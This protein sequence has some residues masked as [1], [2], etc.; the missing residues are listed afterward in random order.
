MKD[1]SKNIYKKLDT[2]ALAIENL[3]N[4]GT[5]KSHKHDINDVNGLKKELDDIKKRL[6]DLEGK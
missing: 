5:V 4:T 2:L 3:S 1:S 6:D